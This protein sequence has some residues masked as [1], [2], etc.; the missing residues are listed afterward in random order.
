MDTLLLTQRDVR[1]VLTMDRAVPAVEHAFAAHGRGETA[2]PAK[3]Y[4]A[5]PHHDGDF[6]AMP[7]YLEG[8]AGVKWV[9][10]HP[11]NPARY[12]LPAVMGVYV[13][14]DPVTAVP[15]AIMDATWMTAVR[16]GAAAAVASKHLARPDAET[17]GLI[18][19]G[20]Q[21]RHIL[22]AHRAVFG[23][24]LEAWTADLSREAAERL[25]HEAGGRATSIE[26]AATADIVCTATPSHKP[27]VR[28][29]WV[30]HGV[31]VDAM[32]ADAEGKQELEPRILTDSRLFVDD[33]E[34]ASH[35]GEI[36]VPLRE[37]RLERHQVTG[38]LGEVVSGRM[39]GRTSEV[40]LTVF[41]STGLAIQDAALARVIYE[42]ARDAGV[43]RTIELIP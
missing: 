43:G 27:I 5:L 26:G 19:C 11:T 3:V 20:V 28:R 15:L 14:N 9:N 13:L 12:G 38:T 17:I 10:A 37:G 23:Q 2:M 16:T 40:S 34:Q 18:G 42:A 31:H 33:W 35:S 1:G 4:L 39:A 36:N 7:A 29:E 25:A 22:E 8:S 6:R 30:R 24:Q 41:D 32:G 21:A